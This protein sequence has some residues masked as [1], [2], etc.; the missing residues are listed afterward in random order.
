M[1]MIVINI[2]IMLSITFYNLFVLADLYSKGIVIRI[3]N[4]RHLNVHIFHS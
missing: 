4:Q 3:N 2:I 1:I